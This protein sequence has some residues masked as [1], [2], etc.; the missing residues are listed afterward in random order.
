MPTILIVE[1]DPGLRQVLELLLAKLDCR[2]ASAPDA[3][4]ALELLTTLST[5]PQLLLTDL[6]LP[7]MDG[8]ELLKRVR[9]K[10]PGLSVVLL[11][12]LQEE[13][14]HLPAAVQPDAILQKPVRLEDLSQLLAK[15]GA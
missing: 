4:R 6:C 5:R 1:D 15:F 9:L 12:G 7:G 8:A 2:V 10:Y 3:E 11:T 14:L 13:S